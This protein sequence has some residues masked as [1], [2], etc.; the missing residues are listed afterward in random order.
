MKSKI[1]LNT[2]FVVFLLSFLY[3]VEVQAKEWKDSI[4]LDEVEKAFE[5]MQEGNSDFSIKEYVNGIVKGKNKF[6]MKEIVKRAVSQLERQLNEQ[7]DTFF[8]IL[9]LGILAGIF[10]NFSG[11]I[12]DRSLSETGIYITYLVLFATMAAGFFTVYE[13]SG[14]VLS[15]LLLFMRALIPSFSL[16]LCIGGGMGTSLAYYET[17]LIAM[18]FLETFMLKVLLPGVQIFFTIGML[19]PLTD[20][21][22]SK[23]AGLIKSFLGWCAKL[24]FGILI[25]YQGLQGL[26][27]PVMDQLKNNTMWQMA[28]GLPGVGNTAGSIADTVAGSGLL[29]KSA[30][31]IGGVVC[32]G[33]ICLYPLLK[34]FVFMI[35]SRVGG[36]VLQPV[37]DR[38]MV[39]A[40]QVAADSGKL[41]IEYVLAGALL[42]VFSIIIVLVSVRGIVCSR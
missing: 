9:A 3:P 36:A 24:L 42:F 22:F 8:Y 28:K 39:T 19:N 33:L 35:M 15:N 16:A 38:K 26:L 29:L 37:S 18:S 23:L 20:N 11:T 25:G 21:H 7:K 6:S 4:S 41:L 27:L 1:F 13:V 12:G 17:M 2:I 30:V 31:G 40:L 10:V 32:I 14:E 5:Q 34:I